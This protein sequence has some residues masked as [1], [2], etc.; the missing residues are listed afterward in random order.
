[1]HKFHHEHLFADAIKFQEDVCLDF[2]GL[3]DECV[4]IHCFDCSLVSI[5]T[6]KTQVSSLVML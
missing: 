4:S 6:N 2:F 3:S 5:F 1:M